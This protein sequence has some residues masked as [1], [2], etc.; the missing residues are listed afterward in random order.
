MGVDA[1]PRAV[2]EGFLEK[3]EFRRGFPRWGSEKKGK[4][5]QPLEPQVPGVHNGN[6]NP[7]EEVG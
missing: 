7:G 4:F 2:R 1:T 3:A 6:K 5:L